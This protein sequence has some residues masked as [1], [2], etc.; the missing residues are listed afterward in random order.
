MTV[1]KDYDID[2]ALVSHFILQIMPFSGDSS[3]TSAQSTSAGLQPSTTVG[4]GTSA[5]AKQGMYG[6]YDKE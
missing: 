4:A 2:S 3:S 5:K 1:S 6:Q